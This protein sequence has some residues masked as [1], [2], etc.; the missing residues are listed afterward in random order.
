MLV[1][2]SPRL[3]LRETTTGV[4]RQ[5]TH[6]AEISTVLPAMPF[7]PVQRIFRR[8]LQSASVCVWLYWLSRNR[9]NPKERG[10][11]LSRACVRKRVACVLFY[12]EILIIARFPVTVLP[13]AGTTVDRWKVSSASRTTTGRRVDTNE[14]WQSISANYQ[15][16][17]CRA[18]ATVIPSWRRPVRSLSSIHS[19]SRRGTLETPC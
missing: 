3:L 7:C 14:G 9:S 13:T 5:G 11:P 10:E 8:M 18:P 4:I 16:V 15:R 19:R 2:F 6:L 17:S 1:I 12:H